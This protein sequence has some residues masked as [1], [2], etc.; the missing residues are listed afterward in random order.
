MTNDVRGPS[1]IVRVLDRPVGSRRQID[2]QQIQGSPLERAEDLP[3]QRELAGRTPRMRFFAGG[4]FEFEGLRFGDD[5][6][7]REDADARRGARKGDLLAAAEEDRLLYASPL[8][9]LPNHLRGFRR[10]VKKTR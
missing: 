8:Q 6:T 9:A 4:A 7:H 5:G 2:E 3:E 1:K 10:E